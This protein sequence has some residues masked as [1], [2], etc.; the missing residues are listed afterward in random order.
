MRFLKLISDYIM[1]DLTSRVTTLEVKHKEC[2]IQ[3]QNHNRR[4]DDHA[5]SNEKQTQ[6]LEDIQ[7]LLASFE[8]T[9]KRSAS[10]YTTFDTLLRWAGGGT[11]IIGLLS[12]ML[13]LG[14]AIKGIL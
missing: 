7:K 12:A 10:N 14:M 6:I 4:H 8:P 1:T 2:E 11:V 13:A 5:K 9:I 3:H